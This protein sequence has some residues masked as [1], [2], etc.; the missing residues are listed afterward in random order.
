GGDGR[1]VFSTLQK[2]FKKMLF[3]DLRHSVA[4]HLLELGVPIE[5][6]S[7]WLGHS[8]IATTAKVYAH[9][10]IGIRRRTVRPMDELLEFERLSE[11]NEPLQLQ[12]VIRYL[13]FD[14]A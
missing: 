12:D 8:N 10:T 11:E 4:T 2:F 14:V 3:H 9:V 5:E 1:K 7:A 13:F 6:V